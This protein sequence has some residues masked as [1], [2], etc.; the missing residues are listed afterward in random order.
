MEQHGRLKVGL[1]ETIRNEY[2]CDE[3]I[4]IGF[5]NTCIRLYRGNDIIGI[6]IQSN[7]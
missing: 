3:S 2:N 1:I 5:T 4:Y 6:R 7:N